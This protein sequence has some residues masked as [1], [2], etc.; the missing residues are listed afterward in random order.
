MN[1]HN[2][3]YAQYKLTD[4]LILEKLKLVGCSSMINVCIVAYGIT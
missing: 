4:M 1:E 2:T 3:N